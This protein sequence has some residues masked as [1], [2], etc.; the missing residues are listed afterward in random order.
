MQPVGLS[1]AW[2]TK[3]GHEVVLG[4]LETLAAAHL[5]NKVAKLKSI[6]AHCILRAVLCR[7]ICMQALYSALSATFVS[8][9][10]SHCN[11]HH[12]H[13]PACIA[14]PLGQYTLTRTL[15]SNDSMMTD[16]AEVSAQ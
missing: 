4:C 13:V 3:T 5:T 11:Q 16:T 7:Q 15:A 10:V 12:Q 9:P 14:V 6:E 2:Q 8:R 1:R